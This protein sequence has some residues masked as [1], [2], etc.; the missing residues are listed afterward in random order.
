[1]ETA[2]A[3]DGTPSRR[4]LLV[5]P[6]LEPCGPLRRAISHKERNW[7]LTVTSSHVDAARLLQES[8]FEAMIYGSTPSA[9]SDVQF[10]T[11][12][13][14]KHT[15]LLRFVLAG[16]DGKT[17]AG[18]FSGSVP[19]VLPRDAETDAIL[20]GIEREFLLH[21][22]MQNPG[23]KR[24]LA[25]LRKLPTVPEVYH[26]VLAE[27]QAPY[28]SLETVATLI[29]NDPVM[30]GKMLQLV[31]SA[32]FGL[33]RQV[34]DTR[35]AVLHLGGERV[36]GIILLAHAFSEFDETPLKS[37][38]VES[39][40]RHSVA[41]ATIARAITQFETHD[42]PLAEQAYTAGLLHD[43]GKLMIAGNLPML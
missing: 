27:L 39:L 38:S 1:M 14:R 30:T 25:Q 33:Q 10:L 35:E 11:E 29:A 23:L 12:V 18:L 15:N 5:A 7:H 43:I 8:P 24:L 41:T 40:W 17:C 3:F 42:P 34:T 37:F 26:Q 20:S 13:G 28:A 21:R 22:L 19:T 9:G 32:F 2:K 4:L 16:A 31:N 6:D 36:K